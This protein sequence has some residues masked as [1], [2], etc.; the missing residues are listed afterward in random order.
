MIFDEQSPRQ[1]IID[2]ILALEFEQLFE[3]LPSR[4]IKIKQLRKEIDYHQPLLPHNE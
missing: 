1:D 3:Y 2:E 4:E